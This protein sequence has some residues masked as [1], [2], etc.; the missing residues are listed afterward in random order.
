LTQDG[1]MK[2]G[3]AF[4]AVLAIVISCGGGSGPGNGSA[5]C[6]INGTDTCRK[7]ELCNDTLGC[8][9]CNVDPDCPA[10]D[11]RCVEGRCEACASNADCGAAL[12]ACWGDH[13]CHAACTANANCQQ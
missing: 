9:Q 5:L 12:P 8:V 10:T 2:T 6:G 7:G 13:Q 11:P 1:A 4:G 3:L